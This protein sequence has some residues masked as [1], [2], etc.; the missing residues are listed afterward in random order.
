MMIQ[1]KSSRSG[2]IAVRSIVAAIVVPALLVVETAIKRLGGVCELLA[3]VGPVDLLVGFLAHV[4]NKVAIALFL[5]GACIPPGRVVKIAQTTMLS[6]ATLRLNSG[7][8]RY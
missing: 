7:R 8:L 1:G 4:G 3:C 2:R 6:Y 5:R